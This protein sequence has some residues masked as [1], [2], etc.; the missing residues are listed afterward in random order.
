MSVGH[1]SLDELTAVARSSPDLDWLAGLMEGEGSFQAGPPSSPNLPILGIEMTDEDVVRR[2]ADILGVTVQ[3]IAPRR[4]R[5]KVT[6]A[7]RIRGAKAVAWMVALYPL[8]GARRRAQVGRAVASYSCLSNRRLD[9]DAAREALNLL[10]SGATVREVAKHFGVS[11]WCI[12][13]LRL[14]RTH[15]HLDRPA[16]SEGR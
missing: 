14:G 8:L 15:R 10:A 4:T 3:T 7:A 13:D 11:I 9:D 12:D 16:L 2:V 1:A 5:W 6:H